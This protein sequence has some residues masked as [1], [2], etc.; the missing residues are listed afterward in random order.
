MWSYPFNRTRK[1]AH[2]SAIPV[3]SDRSQAPGPMPGEARKPVLYSRL[4]MPFVSRDRAAGL[5]VA[6]FLAGACAA[7]MTGTGHAADYYFSD[8]TSGGSGTAANPYCVDP[9][10]SYGDATFQYLVDGAAPDAASGDTF[11]LCCGSPCNTGSCTYNL[12]E[13]GT[14]N[15][16]TFTVSP[17]ADIDDL[18]V[19]PYC[20]GGA[21]ATVILSGDHKNDNKFCSRF[22][23]CTSDPDNDDP[24]GFFYGR[25]NSSG[26][27]FNGDPL[28]LGTKHIIIEKFG[29]GDGGASHASF[30]WTNSDGG[31]LIVENLVMRYKHRSM[32]DGDDYFDATS[33]PESDGIYD[34]QRGQ[35]GGQSAV[36]RISGSNTLGPRPI[37]RNNEIYGICG[38][39]IRLLGTYSAANV[40]LDFHDNVVYNTEAFFDG[41]NGK[42][43]RLTDNLVYD[44]MWC[45]NIEEEVS[46]FDVEGNTI[47]CRG[48]YKL[49][50]SHSCLSGIMVF[51][52]EGGVGNNCTDSGPEYCLARNIHIRGNIVRGSTHANEPG[53]GTGYFSQGIV[54]QAH[55]SA[56]HSDAG[57]GTLGTSVIEN[58]IVSHVQNQWSCGN[59]PQNASLVVHSVDDLLIQNNTVY[60]SACYG[61][62]TDGA[63]NH[64][65]RNNLLVQAYQH[66][67]GRDDPELRAWGTGTLTLENN[68]FFAGSLGGD[69]VVNLN[70]TNYTCAQVNGGSIGATNRCAATSFVNTSGGRLTWD[71]H[72]PASDTANRNA[73]AAQGPAVDVDGQPRNDGQIDIG[74]DELA[75]DD[76]TPPAAPENLRE[77]P[78]P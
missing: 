29:G 69:P 72:L 13:K 38:P 26:W 45:I 70:G 55:T 34:C 20:N 7:A 42:N 12:Q 36:I 33:R 58:N 2:R 52:D 65:V 50:S 28:G 6:L 31:G 35:Y 60:D 9:T 16:M 22:I 51:E 78:V 56:G 77:E 24:E 43:V 73:G 11:H 19:V 63:G 47:E 54:W 39:V 4:F 10:G 44:C 8:C 59:N 48:T 49:T 40:G 68:N 37:F 32:W 62:M 14:L 53:D 74:A 3:R 76:T 57:D 25:D 27:H 18:T 30:F 75:V 15:T 46:D 61:I 67:S 23:P 17:V 21:C 41:H 71:L 66:A 5:V 64:T 1:P